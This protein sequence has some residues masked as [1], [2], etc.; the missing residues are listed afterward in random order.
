MQNK[1]DADYLITKADQ[2]FRM[3][4]R[5]RENAS[6]L[7]AMGHELMAKAV[8]LDVDRERVADQTMTVE[9]VGWND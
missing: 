1:V 8:E 6:E 2:C 9:K 5:D 4:K 3:A 7:E